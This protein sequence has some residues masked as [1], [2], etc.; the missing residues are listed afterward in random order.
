MEVHKRESLDLDTPPLLA[1]F[2][3]IR[4]GGTAAGDQWMLV[5]SF[6]DLLALLG[7]L[8]PVVNATHREAD[9]SIRP[10]PPFG[11]LIQPSDAPG[12]SRGGSGMSLAIDV[13]KVT[14]VLLA[15]SWHEVAAAS[16]ALDSYEYILERPHHPGDR[17][18]STAAAKVAYAQPASR[19][20]S[21]WPTGRS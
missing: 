16:F 14:A 5:P 3:V 18:C 6:P 21:G 17:C 1:A 11:G 8:V 19:S 2:M 15:D 10:K 20:V 4:M 12:Y 9:D 13:D 7:Q